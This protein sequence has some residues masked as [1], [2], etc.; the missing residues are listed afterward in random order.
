MAALLSLTTQAR[1]QEEHVYLVK[2]YDCAHQPTQRSQTGF[3]VRGMRGIVTALH[4]VA[5]CRRVTASSR[6]GFIL[7]EPLTIVNADIDRDVALLSSSQLKK[8]DGGLDP[9]AAVEWESLGTVKAYG[10]PYGISSLERTLAISRPALKPLKD[11]VPAAPLSVL[12][13]R[14][15]PNHLVNVINL[16][17]QLAPGHSG[18]PL[19][20][21][22]SRVVGIANG[23]VKEGSDITW[24]IPFPHLEWGDVDWRDRLQELSQHNPNLLFTAEADQAILKDEFADDFCGRIARLVAESRTEFVVTAGAAI[25]DEIPGLFQSKI[26]LP[27]AIKSFVVPHD[28]LR[29]LIYKT[30]KAGLIESQY[31]NLVSKLLPC[32]PDWG[33]K[34]NLKEHEHFRRY[35][36]RKNG[37]GPIIVI[38]YNLKPDMPDKMYYLTLGVYLPSRYSKNL[39]D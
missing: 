10:H 34:V 39:W 7:D 37:K 22:K 20:D 18:A 12:K 35:T 15:S 5:D 6:E 23:G 13:K 28:H 31:Y 9:A 4:G 3:L 16:Q 33:R 24:A 32:L 1:A 25:D 21:S 11:L 26:E 27:G 8:V 36:F 2:M 38:S 17:G 29:Y 30:G 14:G 19:L